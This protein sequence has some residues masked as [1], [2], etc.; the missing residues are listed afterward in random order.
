MN[1]KTVH[2]S[3]PEYMRAQHFLLYWL[4][5]IFYASVIILLS[6]LPI[7]IEEVPFRNYDKVIHFFEYGI[8]AVLWFRALRASIGSASVLGPAIATFLISSAFG[9]LDELYQNYTPYRVSD[10]YDVA[11]DATGSF[12]AMSFAV[13]IN[14]LRRP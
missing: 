2:L 7:K 5:V 11:A 3:R 13:I 4:P 10:L 8:F 12:T 6:S 14:F 1:A 9:A